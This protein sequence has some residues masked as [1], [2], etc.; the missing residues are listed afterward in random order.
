M[1]RGVSPLLVGVLALAACSASSA[2][3]AVSPPS[4]SP[5]VST[6]ASPDPDQ[7]L[8]WGPTNAEL[9]AARTEVAGWEP[10][11]LAGQVIIG[12]YHGT[13][14]DA[15]ARL[16][17]DL[18]LAGVCLTGANIETREQVRATG[19]AVQR[20]VAEDGRDVPAVIGVDQE[21]GLVSHL[22]E[23][24]T[25]LPPFMASGAAVAGDLDRG[26]A[27][28]GVQA[29]EELARATAVEL[30]SLGFTW[31]FAPDADVTIG[32]SDPTIGTRAAS[33]DAQVASLAT[34]AAVRGFT[35]GGLVS[36][37]KHYPGHGSVTADSHTALPVQKAGLAQLRDRDLLPFD[38]AAEAGAP[39]VMM[40]HIAVE[41]IDPGVPISLSTKGYQL[42]RDR[43][44]DGVAVT[45]SL[46]MG[47]VRR[48]GDPGV[49]ALAAGADLLLMPADTE[50]THAALITA[51]E[52][53][54]VP[55]ARAE[56]AAAKVVALQRWQARRVDAAGVPDGIAATAQAASRAV[57]AAAITQVL[58]E[59]PAGPLTSVRLV[60]GSAGQRARFAAAARR[61]GLGTGSGPRVAL[62]SDGGVAPSEIVVALGWPTVL[63]GAVAASGAQ[64]AYALFGDTAGSFDALAEVLAGAAPPRGALPVEVS[65]LSRSNC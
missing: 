52:T 9:A 56:D 15:A 30:R 65:G 7:S 43:G 5:A 51:I 64:R 36:T 14:P 21:G 46:G 16:V 11:R 17:A 4:D 57:S 35:D 63:T 32:P 1:K 6:G 22:G 3:P 2:G 27:A 55:R 37:A 58:G 20:A 24:A 50:A 8:P 42:L 25:A 33:D 41:A 53:G 29:V 31:V 61:A 39:A 26:D 34:A 47:A 45:D 10:A 60:G 23:L 62:T 49:R 44:F 13:D 12:R 54:G 59:C 40:S 28:E 48:G 18:H 38:A 19:A